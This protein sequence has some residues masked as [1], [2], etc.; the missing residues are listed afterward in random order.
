MSDPTGATDPI[1]EGSRQRR[2][3][4]H[5]RRGMRELDQLLER[6]LDALLAAGQGGA[7]LD[8]LERLLAC[9][10]DQLWRW[11]LGHQSPDDPELRAEI[12]AIRTIRHA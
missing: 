1:D 11:C 6:R 8:C 7:A 12:D 3:R 2:L 10:D 4:W 5:C 9:E